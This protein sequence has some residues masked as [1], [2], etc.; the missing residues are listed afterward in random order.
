MTQPDRLIRRLVSAFVIATMA[1]VAP[2]RANESGQKWQ[3]LF[4]YDQQKLELVEAVPIAPMAKSVRTPGL[5]GAPLRLTYTLS[6]LDD[7]GQTMVTAETQLPLGMRIILTEDQPCREFIP[8]SGYVIVRTDGPAAHRTPAALRMERAN[9]PLAAAAD[10]AVP[11]PFAPGELTLPIPAYQASVALAGPVGSEKIRDTGPDGNRLVIV[12]L[13]DGYTTADLSSGEFSD[14]AASLESAFHARA[15][16]DNLFNATNIYRVDIESNETGADHETYGIYKDTYLNSSFWVN[17]IERLL[18]LTGTGLSRAT[19][20]ANSAVGAGV[21]DVLLVLVNS[22]KYGGS[23]G[24]VA[25]S[26]VH[27][28]ANEIVLH[29]LGHSFAFLADEYETE[30]PGYPAGDYEPNVD[31]DHSG[32]GLKWLVW[33]ESGTPLPTPETVEYDHVVGAFEG[34]RYLSTGIYRPWNDCLMRSLG[35]QFCPVCKEAIAINFAYDID[36]VDDLEPYPGTEVNVDPVGVTFT[37]TPVPLTDLSFQWYLDEILIEGETE[38]VLTITAE[39]MTNATQTLKLKISFATPLVRR[40]TFADNYTWT[41]HQAAPSCC[42]GS[43]GNANGSADEEPTIGDISA[44]IDH[45]FISGAELPCY[46]EAD[47]NLSGSPDPVADD[48]TIGD[49]SLLIDYLFITQSPLSL[50]P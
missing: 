12:I 28:S 35:Q 11:P 10:L 38:Q 13:G 22:T 47:M 2:I 18:T 37:A 34:A 6:W 27:S 48:I 15:P 25:V 14:D 24:S 36:F 31:Y 8:D 33:V 16:W 5:A 21:W 3:L 46:P 9:Q 49:V 42:I 17:D 19:A 41:L 26:S 7:Q 50:C 39:Q 43:V 29:E 23:G 20:A 30:Y 4:H 32:A 40:M 1:L 45:L 44:I